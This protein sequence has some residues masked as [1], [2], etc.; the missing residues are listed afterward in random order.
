M[1]SRR[2]KQF[3][4]ALITLNAGYLANSRLLKLLE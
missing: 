1:L 3:M 4:S 2:S